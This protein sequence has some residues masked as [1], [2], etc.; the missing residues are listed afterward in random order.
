LSR[1]I[2]VLLTDTSGLLATWGLFR[3][4]V[5]LPADARGWREDRVDIVLHHELAHIRRGDWCIQ[6]AAEALRTV[7]W[8]NPLLWIACNRLRRESEQACDDEVLE[9]GVRPRE[10]ATHLLE[11][12]TRCRVPVTWAS[13]IPMAR[14]SMLERRFAAMLNPGLD[15]RPLS[16]RALGI[17]AALILGITLTTAALRAGQ[18]APLPL[19][20]SIYDASGAVVPGVQVTLEGA[21]ESRWHATTDATGRF[22]FPP[23]QPGRYMLEASLAG[24]RPLRQE[25]DL[26]NA[27]DWD[28]AITLQVGALRETVMVRERRVAGPQPLLQPQRAVPVRVGGN[29]RAPRKV[30][31]VNPVYPATM[32]DAGREGVVPIEAV[33]GRDGTVLSVRVL[34]AQVHPDFAMAAVDAVRQWQFEPTLLNGVPVEVVMTVSV[35]FSLAG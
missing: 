13:A 5:L 2:T 29:I 31:H 25:L 30:S 18:N 17:T 10:Y 12:A 19:T 7:Y 33:I 22:E 28:R 16:R 21:E 4:R 6:L 34:S 15:R 1:P 23:V 8:F 9:A 35:E 24:F 3:P 14:P 26:H 27:P 11:L 32:R 20:G